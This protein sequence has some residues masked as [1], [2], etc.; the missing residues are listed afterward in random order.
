MVLV[1]RRRVESAARQ[2]PSRRNLRDIFLKILSQNVGEVRLPFG[3]AHLHHTKRIAVHVS[4]RP[5]PN[6]R[7]KDPRPAYAHP[8]KP[9]QVL[10]SPQEDLAP[11]ETR[12]KVPGQER[13]GG[14][15]RTAIHLHGRAPTSSFTTGGTPCPVLLQRLQSRKSPFP[16]LP[17][18]PPGL[19]L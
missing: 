8:L 6:K 1:F 19:M 3:S 5:A 9:C 18:V 7:I 4:R 17:V 16:A 15:S 13:N 2:A 10:Q 11:A 12:P 14:L